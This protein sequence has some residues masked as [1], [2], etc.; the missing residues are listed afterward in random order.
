MKKRVA[1][2][3]FAVACVFALSAA[4]AMAG[5]AANVATSW[6][7]ASTAV[8][9]FDYGNPAGTSATKLPVETQ[10]AL[11]LGYVEAYLMTFLVFGN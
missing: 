1:A 3:L 5:T 10:I 6:Q 8:Q 9:N 4:P 7:S 11:N 2:L